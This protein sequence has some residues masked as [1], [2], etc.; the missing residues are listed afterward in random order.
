MPH[1]HCE[2][3]S[4]TCACQAYHVQVNESTCL[5]A[6]LLGFGCSVDEQCSLKVPYS[7]CLDGVCQC[8]DN[9]VP[10]RRDKCLPRESLPRVSLSLLLT[11]H[12]ILQPPSW[13][14][15]V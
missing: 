13:T 8:Q 6:S 4:R 2:W 11:S 9:F 10:H 15:S 5:P 14:A 7:R 12:A 1:A 3:E